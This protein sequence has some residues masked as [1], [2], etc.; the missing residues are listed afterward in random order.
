MSISKADAGRMALN[1]DAD[2]ARNARITT[3][4]ILLLSIVLVAVI[5][6]LP[7]FNNYFIP[8]DSGMF[9]YL[10]SFRQSPAS[11]LDTPSELF[12]VTSYIYFF[13]CMKLF[14]MNSTAFHWAGIGLHVIVSL[15]V[16]RLVK[17]SSGK[18]I[19]AWAAAIFF[20]A[21]ERHQEAIMWI[22]AAN[23]TILTLTSV[24]FLI[25][26]LRATPWSRRLALIVLVV[27]LFSRETAVTLA[28]LAV[29]IPLLDGKSWRTAL[30]EAWPV[31]AIT[32]GYI[33]LWLYYFNR[34]IAVS[35]PSF[36]WSLRFFPV[37]AGAVFRLLLTAMPFAVAL[38]MMK[39]RSG[40]AALRQHQ[41][42]ILLYAAIILLA[43][44]P[45]SLLTYQSSIPSRALYYPSAG[46]AGIVGVLFHAWH[47][48]FAGRK[49]GKLAVFFLLTVVSGN[50]GYV[51]LKKDPQ[52]LERAAATH[53]L[54]LALNNLESRL[55][56]EKS[57][58]VENFP[59]DPWIGTAATRWF[60]SVPPENVVF[61]NSCEP[62]VHAAVLNWSD[63]AGLTLVRGQ[64]SG[65]VSPN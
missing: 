1:L 63:S 52:Y 57:L 48:D 55:G 45:V 6:Y 53:Q 15:L 2:K 36:A 61:S 13:A 30:K 22:S 58:C 27:A 14:G 35:H 38:F 50:I 24:L 37:Y 26:W 32:T 7:A 25:L 5:T 44:I 41:K 51:W 39:G 34:D 19:A 18:P 43:L 56:T 31:L 62:A 29:V 16:Y 20:A 46:L 33:C 23:S 17:M 59:L 3:S 4:A 21:Y 60:S 65:D 11:I 42:E 54:I 9:S 49:M 40:T 28:P 8:D 12:R 64:S 47:Q 10:K